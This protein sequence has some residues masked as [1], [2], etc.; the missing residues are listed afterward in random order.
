MDFSEMDFENLSNEKNYDVVITNY[1]DY[2]KIV[3]A[4]IKE[5]N[6]Y[7]KTDKDVEKFINGEEGI[8]E[9]SYNLNKA[10]FSKG[11]YVLSVATATAM[12]LD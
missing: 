8:I 2:R 10:Y 6:P 3:I 4:C 11:K 5:Q 7:L 1:E 12:N 9:A